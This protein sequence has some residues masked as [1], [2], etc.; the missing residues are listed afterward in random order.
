MIAK[1]AL[2]VA[3]WIVL[4]LVC[5]FKAFSDSSKDMQQSLEELKSLRQEI[6][7]KTL[8][9]L[10]L[11]KQLEGTAVAAPQQRVKVIKPVATI[12]ETDNVASRTLLV[13][14]LS[15]EFLVIEQRDQWYRIRLA[16]GREGWIHEDVIQVFSAPASPSSVEKKTQAPQDTKNLLTLAADLIKTINAKQDTAAQILSSLEESYR[17]LPE[18]ERQKLLPIYSSI[19]Q[20]RNKITEYHVYANHFYEKYAAFQQIPSTPTV[21]LPRGINGQLSIQTGK[22]AYE[23]QGDE[24]LTSRDLNFTGS[25][26]LNDRSQVTAALTNRSEVIQTPY[27]T[28]DVRLAYVYRSPTGLH[29]NSYASYNK[30][31]DKNFE[32]NNF[33]ELGAGLNLS[34]PLSAKS[35]FFTD[36]A[37]NNKAYQEEG[38]N[39]Y[40]GGQLNTGFRI[41]TNPNT[42]LDLALRGLVQSSDISFLDF[43]RFVPQFQYLRKTRGGSF[44][45]KLEFEQIGYAE[46]AKSNDFRR[47]RLDLVWSTNGSQRQITVTGKQF[48]NNENFNYLKL[49]LQSRWQSTRGLS[50]SRTGLSLLY[51]HHPQGSEQQVDYLDVRADRASSG[52]SSYLDLS[53]FGRAWRSSDRDHLVDFYSRLGLKISKVQVG[54]VVGAHLLLNKEGSAIKRDGNSFRAGLDLRSQFTI[55]KASVNFAFGYEKAFVYGNEIAIDQNTGELTTGEVAERN[56]TTLQ[57]SAGLRMPIVQAIDFE[58]DI[59]RYEIDLDVSDEVSINPVSSRSRLHVLAGLGYRFGQ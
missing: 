47:E 39:D 3:V 13:A 8:P 34:Y 11:M 16:D 18:T 48:P 30:Y 29:L 24:S 2:T 37:F 7:Q 41:R 31:D 38:S 19:V 10:V 4:C 5:P 54:P 56:P 42:Q 20:E 17:Q 40:S 9:L 36:L 50:F 44:G 46:E 55:N 1:Y 51:V 14:R 32:R 12:R 6:Q 59:R 23:S 35:H 52:K 57:F 26:R 45:A 21:R 49:G 22:S 15:D 28:N 33:K 27:G 53:L 25:M 43:R 58:L